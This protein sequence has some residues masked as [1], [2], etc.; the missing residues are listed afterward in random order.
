M[1]YAE[2]VWVD[3]LGMYVRT[4]ADSESPSSTVVRV[5]FFRPVVDVRDVRSVITMAAQ[6]AWEGDRPYSPPL[7]DVFAGVA[8]NN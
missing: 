3:R 4:E 1:S 2:L 6:L 8:S 7:P 5:P